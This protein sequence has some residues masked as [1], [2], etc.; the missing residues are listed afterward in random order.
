MGDSVW[1]IVCTMLLVAACVLA[2]KIYVLEKSLDNLIEQLDQ[3]NRGERR[4]VE[5]YSRNRRIVKVAQRINDGY[6]RNQEALDAKD[7]D[8]DKFNEELAFFSHDVRTPVAVIQGY[9]ELLEADADE[10]HRRMYLGKI[11]GKLVE[12]RGMIDE[13]CDYSVI[14]AG[15]EVSACK[16]VVVYDLL[17]S[18]LADHYEAFAAKGWEPRIEFDDEVYRV[19][20]PEGDLRRVLS[21]LVGNVLKYGGGE[22]HITLHNNVLHILNRAADPGG[23]DTTR[24]FDRFWRGDPSRSG[25]GNGLG[26]AVARSLCE[27]M[28]IEIAASMQGDVLD[29]SMTFPKDGR[30]P[31]SVNPTTPAEG[32]V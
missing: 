11:R 15:G 18:V 9:M 24:M 26:L 32:R 27:R 8:L 7:G 16:D 2:Y 28:G 17:C 4:T 22:P 14:V 12:M 23:I 21:N 20:C 5:V 25:R 29:V 31:M 13:L 30:V 1:C 6:E 10:G 19:T 3:V